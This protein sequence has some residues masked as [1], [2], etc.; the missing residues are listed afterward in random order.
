M[1]KF[2]ST[3]PVAK[4]LPLSKLSTDGDGQRGKAL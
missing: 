1:N 4:D 2:Q 3:F